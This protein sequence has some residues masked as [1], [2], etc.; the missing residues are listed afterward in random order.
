MFQS[1]VCEYARWNPVT[2][3]AD[4]ASVPSG[5][6][7]WYFRLNW[8]L[9]DGSS[10]PPMMYIGSCGL[11]RA[12]RDSNIPVSTL[13]G[14]SAGSP[15]CASGGLLPPP[16]RPPPPFRLVPPPPPPPP[17]PPRRPQKE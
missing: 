4:C 5:E 3:G 14:G 8:N 2:H 15:V 17:P 13:G 9:T 10:L 7:I 6:K 11:N 12:A 16:R 1:E